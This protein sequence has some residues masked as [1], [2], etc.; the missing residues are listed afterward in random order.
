MGLSGRSGSPVFLTWFFRSE[1][2]LL[3]RIF[4]FRGTHVMGH[5]CSGSGLPLR[6]A[7]LLPIPEPTDGLFIS[8]YECRR[9]ELRTPSTFPMCAP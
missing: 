3:W 6:R 5:L 8:Y 1:G 2:D 9:A 7:R 4:L